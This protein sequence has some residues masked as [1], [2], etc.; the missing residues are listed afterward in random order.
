MPKYPVP[1]GEKMRF[2]FVLVKFK[3]LLPIVTVRFSV[4]APSVVYKLDTVTLCD[5]PPA[6]VEVTVLPVVLNVL[7]IGTDVPVTPFTVVDKLPP[8]I[9]LLTDVETLVAPVTK[10]CTSTITLL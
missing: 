9:V 2:P 4:R 1:E 10:P 6:I 3:L 5:V 8:D 7:F